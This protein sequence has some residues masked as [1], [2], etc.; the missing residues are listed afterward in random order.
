MTLE[1]LPISITSERFA[2]FVEL[3]W[4]IYPGKHR[5]IPP[6]R[7]SL[8]QEL[9]PENRFFTHGTAQCFL[10]LRGEDVVGRIV[11]S[12]DHALADQSVGHFGYFEAIDDSE[13]AAALLAAAEDWVQQ[14]GK[15]RIHGPIDLTIF[16]RYRVQTE[17]F[18]RDPFF[19]EPRSPR[20]YAPLLESCGFQAHLQWRSWD[21]PRWKF[22]P[23]R[24]LYWWRAKAYPDVWERYNVTSF[25]LD[26]FASEVRAMYPLL[27]EAFEK[28]YGFSRISLEEHMQLYEGA[29]R[30]LCPE[31][32]FKGTAP[33]GDLMGFAYTYR[34]PSAAFVAANGD[35]TR[36]DWQ[37]PSATLVLYSFGI[38]KEH[39]KSG[40]TTVGF[41]RSFANML[42]LGFKRAIGALAKE[43]PTVYDKL[44]SA[45]RRYD[46]FAKELSP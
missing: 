27:L 46:V 36:L 9:S 44:G 19:G 18:E 30:M 1:V 42:R 11:A 29:N 31:I 28:N 21:I 15:T 25:D 35:A 8:H 4:R 22:Y 43:G 45:S 3:P 17:G 39:R 13:V 6:L 34:D 33:N 12:V 16:N 20:Y 7:A 41:D 40:L 26:D 32:S 2:D 10:C 24:L 14:R 5:W 23:M 37:T 38:R